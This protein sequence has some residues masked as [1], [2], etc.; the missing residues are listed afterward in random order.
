VQAQEFAQDFPPQC[1]FRLL[2]SEHGLTGVL[3]SENMQAIRFC[4]AL[5]LL[6][7]AVAVATGASAATTATWANGT[8][9]NAW[10]TAGNWDINQVPNS[11]VFD[12]RIST[13]APC[14]LS[15]Q[16]QIGALT[17]STTTANLNLL[18]ASALGIANPA[19]IA[20]AGIILVNKTGGNS[21]TRLRL[22]TTA[23]ITGAG[24]IQLNGVGP[25]A[26]LSADG[27]TVTHGAQH[28]IHGRGDISVSANNAVLVNDGTINADAPSGDPLRIFLSNA[29][30][31]QNNGTIEATNASTLYIDQG[32]L[33]QTGGGSILAV[34]TQSQNSI[35]SFVSLG[36]PANGH[37]PAIS[38]GAI[39]ALPGASHQLASSRILANSVFLNGCTMS[40]RITSPIG[41][42]I[43]ILENGL[44]NDGQISTAGTIRFDA[45]AVISGTGDIQLGDPFPGTQIGPGSISADGVTVTHAA[46]HTIHGY[47]DGFVATNNAVL[48]NNGIFNG[49]D[50]GPA[51]RP[52]RFLLS[53]S[54]ANQNNGLLGGT[55]I[56]DGGRLDQTGGG[57][58]GGGTLGG[59]RVVLGPSQTITVVGGSLAGVEASS[60]ILDGSNVTTGTFRVLSNGFTGI[61]AATLTN[62]STMTLEA[63]SSLL[64]FDANN[65]AI[66]GS[67]AIVLTN[68]GKLEIS[69][70]Q[71]V[72][73]GSQHSL[74]GTGTI[75]I[76]AGA[77]LTNNGII[78]ASPGLLSF[79]GNL[80]LSSS[81][82]LS[83]EIGGTTQG[84]DYDLLQKTD[85][86]VLTLN[87]NLNLILINGFT[88]AS[89]DKFT[90]T[91]TQATL[92]GA[93]ANVP[94][95]ARLATVAGGGSFVVA[96]NGNNVVLSDFVASSPTPT[97]TPTPTATPTPT[98]GS[99]AN[100]STRVR[101]RNGDGVLIGGVIATGTSGKKIIVRAIG[102]ALADVGVPGALTDPTLELFQGNTSLAFND[103]WRASIQQSEIAQSGFAPT[104]DA[105]SAIIW[106]LLP[107]QNYTAIVRGKDGQNGVGLVEAF[108]LD[109]TSGSQLGNISSRGFVDVDDNVMIAGL[110]VGP[111][112]GGSLKI[113]VRAL[114]P[115]LT[116]FGVPAVLADPS[117]DLVNSN[118]TVIRSNDDWKD[119]Q[120]AEIEAAHLQPKYD[121]EAALVETLEP[122]AYTAVVR[123]SGRTTG[124]GLVEVYT[125][126]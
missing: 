118:G 12:V 75:Q 44:I 34:P 8:G 80:Q 113:L 17:L 126:P 51:P 83:I 52:L 38:G 69:A 10:E 39:S 62:T 16:F 82:N 40:G 14:N 24:N 78:G 87:G 68:G 25:N 32:F 85:A 76:D 71:S 30:G 84:T 15:S 1:L 111:G 81:S 88:P 108:D 41:G 74:K 56:L 4:A 37:S 7:W 48:V 65:T 21:I 53:G 91:T 107:G 35:V 96:Y 2:T 120:R 122:G 72:T 67:G 33:D 119:F 116:D 93:F 42:L 20:N 31:N 73:N 6:F 95:G 117:L 101:V 77:M 47:G 124:V 19:G 55:L 70:G 66:D 110:I 90:I 89:T 125:I 104:K 49:D 115:T 94:S 114:G 57:T 98:P 105:E 11:S 46:G 102:P 112:N 13:S 5:S 23:T 97:P 99:F 54:S 86:G 63:S 92:A 18:P 45:S 58:L 100:I 109:Q 26:T 29:P 9:S 61:T 28:T 3:N 59:G 121:A 64:R 22:D 103:D 36:D 43:A 79:S 27:V 123:G 106:T 50:N 60:A